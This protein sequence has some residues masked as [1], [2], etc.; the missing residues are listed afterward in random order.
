MPEPRLLRLLI[1]RPVEVERADGTQVGGTL[2]N[3]SQRSLWL[4]CG[5]EDRIVPMSDVV[6]LRPAS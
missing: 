4:V 3:V 6:G 2:F 1:G 5:D